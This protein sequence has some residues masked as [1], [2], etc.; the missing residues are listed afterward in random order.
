MSAA[1]KAKDSK[2]EA[3][4]RKE[5]LA[6]AIQTTPAGE[7]TKCTAGLIERAETLLKYLRDGK[8]EEA[9]A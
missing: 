8:E 7:G 6:A 5:A 4:L 9:K 1:S 2:E 3:D